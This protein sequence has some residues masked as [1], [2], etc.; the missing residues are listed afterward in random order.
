VRHAGSISA[1]WAAHRLVALGE[2]QE[3]AVPQN[4][5]QQAIK[6]R[7]G[8]FDLLQHGCRSRARGLSRLGRGCLTVCDRLRLA[9]RAA[10]R[11][12]PTPRQWLRGNFAHA[13]VLASRLPA[14]W[15]R[16]LIKRLA[17]GKRPCRSLDAP[18]GHCNT[19]PPPRDRRWAGGGPAVERG[20]H[21]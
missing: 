16:A 14:P 17:Q 12:P 13:A 9:P 3:D 4:A 1:R 11:Q 19:G 2:R 20:Q 21:Q 5:L 7:V 15:R 8:P 6:P 18:A 10:E